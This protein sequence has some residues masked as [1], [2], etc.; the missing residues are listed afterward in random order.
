MTAAEKGVIDAENFEIGGEGRA[1]S[2]RTRE[3][4][5]GKGKRYLGF[6]VF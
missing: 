1:E 3:K 2:G 4:N 5:R 6:S